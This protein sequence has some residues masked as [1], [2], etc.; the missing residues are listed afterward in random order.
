M[1]PEQLIA[2]GQGLGSDGLLLFNPLMGG[3][4][5]HEAWRMLRLFETKVLPHL[6]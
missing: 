5:I 6:P 1:T 2:L 3:I 4:P